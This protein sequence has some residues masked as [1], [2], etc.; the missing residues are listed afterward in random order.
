MKKNSILKAALLAVAGIGLF[1]THANATLTYS[2]DDLFIGFY[3]VNSSTDYLIDI[4]QASNFLNAASGS[5]TT[6]GTFGNDLTTAFGSGWA[7]DQSVKWVVFG[8][9]QLH[10]TSYDT[11][12]YTNYATKPEGVVGTLETGYLRNN[13]STQASASNAMIGVENAY[14]NGTLS[15]EG[16]YLQSTAVSNSLYSQTAGG[17]GI[18]FAN[19]TA[20][21]FSNGTSQSVLDLFRMVKVSSVDGST[22]SYVGSFSINDSGTTSFTVTAV[23]EPSTYGLAVLG[24]AAA[25]IAVRRFRKVQA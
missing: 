18:A 6:I 14:K 2:S 7:T 8:T 15:G 25:L 19:Y 13:Q 3:S 5:T 1:A 23:P 24:G 22:G 21:D 10:T 20:G 11:S 12:T 16:G 17:S 4:G 9:D